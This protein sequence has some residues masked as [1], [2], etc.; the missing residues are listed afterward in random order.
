[1]CL[2]ESN[3]DLEKTKNEGQ[4]MQVSLPFAFQ[5]RSQIKT[6]VVSEI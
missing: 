3:I 4:E 5:L 2:K 1:M 6:R